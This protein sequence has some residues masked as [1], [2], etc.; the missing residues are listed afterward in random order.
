[1][2]TNLTDKEIEKVY[3]ILK[4]FNEGLIVNPQ[5]GW[6]QDYYDEKLI[7]K[8]GLKQILGKLKS[9]LHYENIEKVEKEVLLR[10]YD[11]FNNIID[12]NVEKNV[13]KAF[14]GKLTL[15]I[16]YFSMGRAEF[17]KRK[18][19]IYAKNS[20]YI[21]GYCHSKNAIRKFRTSRIGKAKVTQNKY[22]I[23]SNF[24]KKDYF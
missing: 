24:N 10:K 9:S 22:E 8:K 17:T 11:T 5:E 4:A 15:E 6:E 16:E 23:P 2:M 19:D 3:K 21:V 7:D 18:V 20:K 12:E 14:N 1:M 13:T